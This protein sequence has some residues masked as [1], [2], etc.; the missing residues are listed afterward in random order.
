VAAKAA[1]LSGPD[2]A[3]DW[4][5]HGGVLVFDDGTHRVYGPR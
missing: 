4:L 2:T 3:S 5:R 1:L